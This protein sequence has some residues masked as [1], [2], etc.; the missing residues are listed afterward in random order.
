MKQQPGLPAPLANYP[1]PD[2]RQLA[3]AWLAAARDTVTRVGRVTVL[4][5]VGSVRVPRHDL[6]VSE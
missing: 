1:A 6:A 3:L 5:P 2:A 4:R